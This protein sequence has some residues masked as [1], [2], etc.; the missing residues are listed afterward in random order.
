MVVFPGAPAVRVISGGR[1][2][3]LPGRVCVPA[4]RGGIKGIIL[5]F[6]ITEGGEKKRRNLHCWELCLIGAEISSL[7]LPSPAGTAPVGTGAAQGGGR[8]CT[9]PTQGVTAG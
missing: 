3:V 1:S 2:A 9:H 6:V 5:L 4:P 7:P 8:H